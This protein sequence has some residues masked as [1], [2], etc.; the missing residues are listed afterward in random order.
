VAEIGPLPAMSSPAHRPSGPGLKGIWQPPTLAEMQALLP[1]YQFLALL[2]RGGMGAVFKATQLSLNRSVAIKVLPVGLIPDADAN[3]AA[4]FRREALTMAKLNHPGIVSVHESGEAGGLLYIVMEFVDGTD[5]AR[6][7]Q[8]EGK[9][10]PEI[11]T[12]LLTQVCDALHYAHE[13]GVIHRDI[14]PANLLI[15]RNGTV[16]I[17]DFGLAKHHDDALLGLTKTN[18]AV[19]TPDFLAPEA[20]TPGTPL[21]A[22][23]D[24][25]SVGVTLYQMLTGEIPRGLWEMPSTRV[26]TDPRFDAIIERAMQPRPEARYQSSAD[27]RR[28]LEKIQS[29]AGP[30]RAPSSMETASASSARLSTSEPNTARR[31][32]MVPPRNGSLRRWLI[33]SAVIAQLCII[34]LL[35]VLWPRLPKKDSLPLAGTV[36]TRLPALPPATV[37]EA[38]R[39]LINERAEFKILSAGREIDVKSEQDIPEGDFQI[40]YLWFDRW[41]SSPPQPPPPEDEFEVMHAVK[42]LRFAFLRMPGLSDAAFAFLAGNTNLTTLTIACPEAI[43]DN[44]LVHLAGLKKLEKLEVAFS[45]R[46]TGRKFAGSAWLAS[47]QEVDLLGAALEDEALGVLATCPRLTVL[48]LERTAITRGGLRTLA[49][50]PALTALELVG[51]SKIAESDFIESLPQFHRLRKLDLSSTDFGDEAAA[52]VAT[53]TNLTTLS[54][55]GTKLT[56]VGLARLSGLEHLAYLTVPRARVT[57]EGIAGFEL[58]HPQCRIQQ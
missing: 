21:D 50:A 58:A 25:Y 26:G 15:T 6:M 57:P 43:T 32:A 23:A 9:L 49:R 5:V 29:N 4:R 42:T 11:A 35:I 37:H 33:V 27:L 14:K 1:A 34:G 39:W 12:K 2:G 52:A 22:R 36:P 20:W 7:I 54:L 19:G 10:E 47:V 18:I 31:S 38:A 46:L 30:A 8:S 28:D 53:L 17:A 55:S 13:H 24:L 44:V 3:F 16:K 41:A 56:D 40:V 51:C 48:K 45:P